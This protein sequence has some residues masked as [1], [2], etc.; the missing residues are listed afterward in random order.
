[1]N[2]EGDEAVGF[3]GPVRGSE[4]EGGEG[5]DVGGKEAGEGVFVGWGSVQMGGVG[6]W[7]RE[8]ERCG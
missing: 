7:R 8:R 6:S 4:D 3:A 5:E 1:M 2:R